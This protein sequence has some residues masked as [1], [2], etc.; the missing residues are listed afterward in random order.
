MAAAPETADDAGR[1]KSLS[2]DERYDTPPE[3]TWL[4]K[5]AV[6]TR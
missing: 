4:L 3:L 1:T 6:A 2:A 5:N